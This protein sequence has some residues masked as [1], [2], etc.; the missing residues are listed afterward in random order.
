MF[1]LFLFCARQ[2]SI[3]FVLFIVVPIGIAQWPS[4]H[5]VWVCW[6]NEWL[7]L[8]LS[9]Y[10]IIANLLIWKQKHEWNMW[11]TEQ[12]HN[13]FRYIF[14]LKLKY[15]S[16]LKLKK[17]KYEWTPTTF[18]GFS[19]ISVVMSGTAKILKHLKTS[20]HLKL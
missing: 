13:L 4:K 11:D 15:I 17:A 18:L 7:S 8:S 2:I 20:L 9:N 5:R 19:V 14:S 1:I 10:D 6:M 12:P 3:M 16:S